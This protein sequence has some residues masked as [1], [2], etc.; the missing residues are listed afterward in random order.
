M[1]VATERRE[2]EMEI[3]EEETAGEATSE[4]EEGEG[5]AAGREEEGRG[6]EGGEIEGERQLAP[7]MK[8]TRFVFTARA[9]RTCASRV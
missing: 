7:R 9:A 3:R 4:P 1:A 5:A 8:K 2:K 6:R